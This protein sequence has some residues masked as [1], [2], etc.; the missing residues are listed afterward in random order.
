M[1]RWPRTI[2]GNIVAFPLVLIAGAIL[3]QLAVALSGP[4]VW[5][6]VTISVVVSLGLYVWNAKVRRARDIAV[7]GA[8]SFADA[9]NRR[10]PD[11][12]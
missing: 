7:A 11:R 1:A 6:L 8:P 9:V 10:G 12:I 4:V 5:S 3:V 2:L